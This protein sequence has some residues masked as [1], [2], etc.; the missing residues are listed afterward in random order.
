V[1]A[2]H[3]DDRFW[4]TVTPYL[5][6]RERMEL[7]RQQVDQII[8]LLDLRPGAR[9][10]DMC[11]GVGRHALDFARRG[12]AV[13]GVDRTRAYLDR[14]R[15]RAAAERLEIELVE[16][17]ARTFKRPRKFDAAVNLF[18]SFG[19]FDDAADDLRLAGNVFVSLKSDGRFVID[20]L[21]REVL[22]RV[23]S[24]RTWTENDDGSFVLEERKPGSAWDRIDSR[25]IL[26]N[27]AERKEFTLS[28]RLY[29]GQE[30]ASLLKRAGFKNV[31]LHGNLAGAPYDDRAQR[32]VAVAKK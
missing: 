18:S 3:E 13:T 22:A 21:G 31:T 24:E 6:S 10:L 15:A 7:A 1:T 23:F 27:R 30:I 14:A 28:L 2:W 12:Y 9:V 5:F 17:D 32:L 16:S 11:C 29:S 8:K 19:Y 4:E 26:V 20:V 25:W